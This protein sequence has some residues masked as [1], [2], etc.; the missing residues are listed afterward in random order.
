MPIIHIDNLEDLRI[1]LYTNLKEKTLQSLQ[2]GLFIGEGNLITQRLLNSDFKTHSLLVAQRRLDKIAPLVPDHIPLYVVPN[3]LIH[4][5]VGYKFHAG[6]LSIGH[7][8][9]TPPISEFIN[10]LLKDDS[11]KPLTLLICPQIRNADNLGTMI[12]NAAAF[13]IDALITGQ[14]STDL[15]SRRSIRVSMGTI[16]SIPVFQSSDINQTLATLKDQHQFTNAATIL[17]HPNAQSLK[18][19]S[20]PQNPDRLAILLGSEDLG[21]SQENLSHCNQFLTIPMHHGTDS[22]NIA[23]AGAIFLYH[24]T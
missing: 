15:Y 18:T 16:F 5:I 13:G 17:E 4:Q 6:I 23:T 1:N 10:N 19:I 14:G 20:R 11:E 8:K 21:L 22:L 12:R 9:Q 3:D 24:L 2:G 7:Q